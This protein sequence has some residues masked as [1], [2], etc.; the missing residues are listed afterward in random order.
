[1]RL[2]TRDRIEEAEERMNLFVSM[3]V[4]MYCWLVCVNVIQTRVI[5]EE[6]SV[7]KIPP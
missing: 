2:E 3:L 6:A 7:G 4:N 1:M 5:R